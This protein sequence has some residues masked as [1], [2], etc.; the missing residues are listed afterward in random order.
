[1]HDGFTDVVLLGMVGS[2]LA[3]EVL[4]A[5]LGVKPGRPRFRM[6]DSVNR[7]SPADDCHR[8][9]PHAGRAREQ[10]GIDD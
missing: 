9:A 1:M 6:V 3:P 5:V 4:R 7:G 8:P 2:S 10:V